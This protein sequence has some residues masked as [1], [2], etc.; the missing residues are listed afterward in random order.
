[1]LLVDGEA[2]RQQYAEQGWRHCFLIK[3]GSKASLLSG[4]SEWAFSAR[5]NA[6]TASLFSAACFS[7]ASRTASAL[8]SCRSFALTRVRHA[9]EI[10]LIIA[11]MTLTK[12]SII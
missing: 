12:E 9:S 10:R 1:M 7:N 8:P 3:S 6:S 11:G 4:W 2:H 5:L